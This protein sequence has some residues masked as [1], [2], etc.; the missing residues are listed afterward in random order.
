MPTGRLE[1]VAIS[2][3]NQVATAAHLAATGHGYGYGHLGYAGVYG[4]YLG[5]HYIGKRDADADASLVGYPNGA[6]VP[7]NPYLHGGYA[8]GV[9]GGYHGAHYIGKRDA[10]ADADA[11]LVGY[12]NGAL[13]P[14]NPYLHGGYAHGVYGGYHGA[15]YIGKRDADADAEPWVYGAGAYGYGYGYAPLVHY[16]PLVAHPN[17]AVVPLE[18]LA[19]SLS[20]AIRG[21]GS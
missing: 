7:Y 3:L 1:T 8:H 15:H 5:A 4:G 12:P 6:L 2:L 19:V 18:P 16:N 20:L 11:S 10:D 17:G 21:G 13:V 9:Y 14:Y